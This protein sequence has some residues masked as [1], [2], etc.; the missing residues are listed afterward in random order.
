[1]YTPYE[2]FVDRPIDPKL[3][4]QAEQDEIRRNQLS[5][6]VRRWSRKAEKKEKKKRND[7]LALKK[8]NERPLLDPYRAINEFK[9]RG[10]EAR[11]LFRSLFIKNEY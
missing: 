2:D 6:E 10:A 9:Y 5:I 7:A 1:M 8:F 4:R 11:K 3:L